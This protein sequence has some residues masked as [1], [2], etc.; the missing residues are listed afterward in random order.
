M[1]GRSPIL[2]DLVVPIPRPANCG[3]RVELG[4]MLTDHHS[5][6]RPVKDMEALGLRNL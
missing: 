4:G 1:M 2:E 3:P 6:K 5:Y